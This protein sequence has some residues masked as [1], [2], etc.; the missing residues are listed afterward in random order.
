MLVFVAA[1]VNAMRG[2]EADAVAH[3]GRTGLAGWFGGQQAGR[4]AANEFVQIGDLPILLQTIPAVLSR[5]GAFLAS[6]PGAALASKGRREL[7]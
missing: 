7:A 2:E 1:C 6:N 5:R 4:R 3:S